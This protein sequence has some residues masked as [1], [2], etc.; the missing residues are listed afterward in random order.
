M[1]SFSIS[2]ESPKSATLHTNVSL[3]K[4]L[5]AAKSYNKN[6]YSEQH[7]MWNLSVKFNILLI[8]KLNKI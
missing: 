1:L 4:M 3:T 2:R 7:N 6:K 5:R 8:I